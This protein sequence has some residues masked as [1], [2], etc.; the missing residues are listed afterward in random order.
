MAHNI[1][2]RAHGSQALVW[3]QELGDAA[4]KWCENLALRDELQHDNKTMDSKNQGENLAAITVMDPQ[5]NGPSPNACVLVV[6]EWYGELKNY[7]F[8]TGLPKGPQ[9]QIK[10]FAQVT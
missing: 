4:Q 10:H 2:R 1:L 9:V 7:N 3:S 8:Q 6:G 5:R